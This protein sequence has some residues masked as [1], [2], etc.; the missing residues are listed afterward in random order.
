MG[1]KHMIP[2]YDEIADKSSPNIILFNSPNNISLYRSNMPL[3]LKYVEEKYSF[4]ENYN[5]YI[6]YKKK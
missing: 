1:V 2:G 3:T 6:F 4:Y 5:G